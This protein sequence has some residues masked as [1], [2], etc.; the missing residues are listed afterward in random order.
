MLDDEILRKYVIDYFR[1][2]CF[3]RLSVNTEILGNHPIYILKYHNIY[4][5]VHLYNPLGL[6]NLFLGLV[7]RSIV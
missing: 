3:F 4:K 1:P 7:L 5:L 6:Y 2:L